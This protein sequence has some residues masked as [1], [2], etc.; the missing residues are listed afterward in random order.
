MRLPQVILLAL[1]VWCSSCAAK[2]LAM[3]MP[4]IG[5][6]IV[7]DNVGQTVPFNGIL[8]SPYYLN[9]YMQW[10]CSDEGIC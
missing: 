8:F 10:K 7:N 4:V 3:P 9:E 2:H 6:D 5:V 1:T